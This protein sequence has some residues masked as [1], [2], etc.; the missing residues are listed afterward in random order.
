VGNH[1]ARSAF[2]EGNDMPRMSV[3]D[4]REKLIDAA[5]AVMAREG[6]ANATTRGIVAE[7]GMQI[8]VFHYCFRSRDELI[9]EVARAISAR[10]F[11]AVGEV[12]ERTDDPAELIRGCVDAFWRHI[13]NDP[14]AWQLI[15]ELT[16]FSLRQPGWESAARAN[17]TRNI[18]AVAG[19]LMVVGEKEAVQWRSPVELL[20]PYVLA[21]IEGI[22]FQWLV[23]R[24]ADTARELFAHLVDH[25]YDEAGLARSR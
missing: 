3:A 25:L 17:R 2:L 4:R 9:G 24:E 11:G 12:L 15:F 13:E 10:S 6:V 1:R 14:L 22:T 21:T 7:A 18:D 20:A 19:L 16:H 23:H 5:I 8:G